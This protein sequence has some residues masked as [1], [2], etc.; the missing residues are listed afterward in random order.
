VAEK[1][2]KK[3]PRIAELAAVVSV[4]VSIL[5][6]STTLLNNSGNLPSWWFSFSLIVLIAL[7]F[8]MPIMIFANPVREKFKDV[9][10]E[11]KRNSVSRKYASEFKDLVERSRI[12]NY[13]TRTIM[14]SLRNQYTNDIKSQL[15]MSSLQD[16][17]QQGTNDIMFDIEKDI[18]ASDK[19]Y[20]DLRL[21]MKRF[22][23][24][25]DIHRRNLKIIEVF[26]HE[27]MT[28]AEKPIA[29][30]IEAEFE[31]FREKYNDFVKDITDFCHKVNQE[32]ESHEFPER[33]F[34][35]LKKW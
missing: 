8:F 35:Y 13:D 4:M 17:G 20:R 28:T 31:A 22:E 1:E 24:V 32:S 34:Q 10:L 23:S 19:T 26:A 2:E 30:G 6:A 14:D 11:R 16:Y 7:I 5:I 3:G 29:K 27:M 21:I 15:A 12:L 18:D 25:S 33:S 9:R